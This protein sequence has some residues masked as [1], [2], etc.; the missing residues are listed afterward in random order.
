MFLRFITEKVIIFYKQFV[1]VFHID[2]INIL[3]YRYFILQYIRHCSLSYDILVISYILFRCKK[4]YIYIHT[5]Y[6][7]IL[8]PL[9]LPN[10]FIIFELPCSWRMLVSPFLRLSSVMD[11]HLKYKNHKTSIVLTDKNVMI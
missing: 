7:P 8:Y 4:H 1:Y 9:Y 10:V 5:I 3:S 6:L 11:I 2:I